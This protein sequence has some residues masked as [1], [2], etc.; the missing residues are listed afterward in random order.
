MIRF[1]DIYLNL[2]FKLLNIPFKILSKT[3]QSQ[4]NKMANFIERLR[5]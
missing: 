1:T 5:K 3:N 2:K 4:I